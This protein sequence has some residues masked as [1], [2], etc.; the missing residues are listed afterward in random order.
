MTTRTGTGLAAGVLSAFFA[1]APGVSQATSPV[2]NN[3]ECG[4]A[5]IVSASAL[6]AVAAKAEELNIQLASNK[7][8]PPVAKPKPKP[9]GPFARGG[10]PTFVEHRVPR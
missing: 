1:A 9:T 5:T 6:E 3:A 2:P 10:P 4:Q 7:P 8:K